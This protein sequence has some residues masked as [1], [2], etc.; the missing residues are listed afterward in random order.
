[1]EISLVPIEGQHSCDGPEIWER[2][3]K[4]SGSISTVGYKVVSGQQEV[5]F[6]ALDRLPQ[7]ETL[8]LY[9]LFVRVDNRRQGI[10]SAVLQD[11]ERTARNEGFASVT[12]TAHPLDQSIEKHALVTWYLQHGYQKDAAIADQMFKELTV[13]S[14]RSPG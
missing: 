10:G 4:F 14:N 8:V 1:M 11:V 2:A 13:V 6:V 9:E 3:A 5:A 7:L 12:L